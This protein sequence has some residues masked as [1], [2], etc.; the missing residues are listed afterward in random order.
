MTKLAY[1]QRFGVENGNSVLTESDVKEINALLDRGVATR[2][3]AY[4]FDVCQTTIMQIK[5]G[6]TWSQVST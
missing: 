6:L 1:Q 2:E 5:K 4:R 3:I